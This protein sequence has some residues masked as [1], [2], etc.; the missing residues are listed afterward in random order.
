MPRYDFECQDCRKGFEMK[1]SFS[2]YAAQMKEKKIKCPKCGSKKV[3]RVYSAPA[4]VFTKS[5]SQNSGG[6]CCPGGKCG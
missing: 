4:V 1:S 6:C 3:I 5:S 2:E